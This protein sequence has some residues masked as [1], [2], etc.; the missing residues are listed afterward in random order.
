M[1][2]DKQKGESYKNM[3]S[4]N[5]THEKYKIIYCMKIKHVFSTS[6]F[7]LIF[8]LIGGLF[9][10]WSSTHRKNTRCSS[11]ILNNKE[12]TNAAFRHVFLLV[13]INRLRPFLWHYFHDKCR[14]WIIVTL[15]HQRLRFH[16]KST[17]IRMFTGSWLL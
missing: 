2:F 6:N 17:C 4:S 16:C 10:S 15:V 9:Y 13:F 8:L 11:F 1:T 3:S 5:F 14:V 12:K 7:N